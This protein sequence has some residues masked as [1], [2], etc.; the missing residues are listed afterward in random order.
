M[1][2]AKLRPRSLKLMKS[3]SSRL[4]VKPNTSSRKST[5]LF[6]IDKGINHEDELLSEA[7]VEGAIEE[8]TQPVT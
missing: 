7:E 6:D 2:S 1:I 8:P 5:S 3:T 4:P